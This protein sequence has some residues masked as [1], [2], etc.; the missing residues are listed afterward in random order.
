MPIIAIASNLPKEKFRANFRTEFVKFCEDIFDRKGMII[1]HI[2]SGADIGYG[3]IED[4]AEQKPMLMITIEAIRSLTEDG[5]SLR[6]KLITDHIGKTLSI[7]HDRIIVVFKPM[8]AQNVGYAGKVLSR[9][10]GMSKKFINEIL[11]EKD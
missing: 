4:F 10:E 11:N 6:T 3:N 8:L 9:H 2:Q 7:P 5:N 1:L